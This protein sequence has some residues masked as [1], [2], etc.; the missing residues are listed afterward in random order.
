MYKVFL[1]TLYLKLCS[2]HI[3]TTKNNLMTL[4]NELITKATV[5]YFPT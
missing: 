3:E 5:L 1:I 2:K 4:A